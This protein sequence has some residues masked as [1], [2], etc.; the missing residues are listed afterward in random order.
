MLKKQALQKGKVIKVKFETQPLPDAST[1]FLVGDFNDWSE[2]SHPMKQR[3][4]DKCFAI[5]VKLEPG[6]E[7]Q[8]RYLVDGEWHNDWSADQYVQNEF[9]GDNSVVIT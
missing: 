8:F 2:T 4:T 1:V 3:K 5:D 6:R 9:G 7:Y